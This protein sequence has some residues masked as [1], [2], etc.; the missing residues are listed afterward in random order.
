MKEVLWR[1]FLGQLHSWSLVAQNI[2]REFVK[3][4][5]KVDLYSTNGIS[6]FPHDL[7]KYLIGYAT[8]SDIQNLDKSRQY[9]VQLSYTAMKN[10]P[11]YFSNGKKNRFG[12]WCYEFA[13]KNSLPEG[14][15]K[16][17]KYVDKL[18]PPSNHAKMVFMDS[19]I[20]ESHM[21]VLPHGYSEEFINRKEKLNINTKKFIFGANIAQPHLRK[22]IPGILEAFGKA[23]SKKDDVCLLL[24]I[25]TKISNQ[26]FEVNFQNILK[27]FKNKYKN[28]AEIIVHDKYVDYISDFYRTCNAIISLSH[29][30]SFLMPALETLASKKILLASNYGGHLDFCNESNSFLVNGKLIR[31]NPKMLYWDQK[32]NT[33]VFEPNIDEAA[34]KM[35]FIVKNE[36]QILQNFQE[37]CEQI[38]KDYTWSNIYKKLEGI[39]E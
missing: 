35:K 26:P 8:G 1:G 28:H 32:P 19:G 6:H 3:N 36:A 37:P 17:Y 2:S 25:S 22:N 14:F 20:P 34:E 12:I 39:I 18:L 31:A 23:F 38:I 29:A 21:M 30:E 15:A 5:Y 7:E 13:G 11:F 16:N 27:A 4:N 10:F 24:K 33:I 9:D